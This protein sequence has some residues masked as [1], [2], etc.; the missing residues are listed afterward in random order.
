MSA[1]RE[2]MISYADGLQSWLRGEDTPEA[3]AAGIS[4]AILLDCARQKIVK[5]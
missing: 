2:E 1:Q 4:V 5:E 3:L